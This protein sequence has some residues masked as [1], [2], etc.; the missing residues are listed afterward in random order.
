MPRRLL[1]L[2]AE[3]DLFLPDRRR[4]V[5]RRRGRCRLG[6]LWLR[7]GVLVLPLAPEGDFLLPDRLL[8]GHRQL[9]ATRSPAPSDAS[10]V[11]GGALRSGGTSTGKPDRSSRPTNWPGR[12]DRERPTSK[13]TTRRMIRS[14]SDCSIVCMP[15]PV[16]VCITE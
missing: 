1:L 4:L 7:R 9:P 12:L 16:F 15:R 14:P 2:P 3:A 8:V 11:F 13:S 5:R 10:S 6:R